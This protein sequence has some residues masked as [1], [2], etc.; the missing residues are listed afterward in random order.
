MK[1]HY[2]TILWVHKSSIMS[3]ITGHLLYI[4]I[5]HTCIIIIIRLWRKYTY[6]EHLV[7]CLREHEIITLYTIH[8]SS[9]LWIPTTTKNHTNLHQ[10]YMAL[11]YNKLLHRWNISPKI[12]YQWNICDTIQILFN[13]VLLSP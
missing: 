10:H 7:D 8:R 12:L 13:R 2:H 3:N 9:L 6:A 1:R 5:K 11:H 4:Y